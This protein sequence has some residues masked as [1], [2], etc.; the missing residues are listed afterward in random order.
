M[1]KRSY[2]QWTEDEIM[3]LHQMYK[4]KIPNNVIARGLQRTER[5]VECAIKN[6]L[7]QKII[8]TC[9]KDTISEYDLEEEEVYEDLIPSKYNVVDDF[10][11]IEEQSNN[12]GNVI[13]LFIFIASF[14]I[15]IGNL[16]RIIY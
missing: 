2:Y 10:E 14:T 9:S 8:N 4:E 16:T 13:F 6:I 7:L 1:P 15:F 3:L 5:S 11:N 12:C